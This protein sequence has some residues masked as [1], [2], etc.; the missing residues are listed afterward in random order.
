MKRFTDALTYT[1]H[2]ITHRLTGLPTTHSVVPSAE[3]LPEEKAH[4]KRKAES[5]KNNKKQSK[6]QLR[7]K[8]L[9]A[10]TVSLA[11]VSDVAITS[12]LPNI[13]V[14]EQPVAT[15]LEQ[16]AAALEQ[17]AAVLAPLPSQ[18]SEQPS[19]VDRLETNPN[20]AHRAKNII[21]K[22]MSNA[23]I[24]SFQGQDTYGLHGREAPGH[25][26]KW[27]VTGYEYLSTEEA[28]AEM[29][30]LETRAKMANKN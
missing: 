26:R 21:E 30:A 10:I 27:G 17:L 11:T 23:R 18:E 4:H 20:R 16:P 24:L 7:D 25:R 9:N 6:R 22:H 8:E 12:A 14:L 2:A 1:W 19:I 13:A 3:T 29:D 28:V 15:V 5:Q